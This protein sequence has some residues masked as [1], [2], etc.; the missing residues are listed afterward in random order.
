MLII[1]NLYLKSSLE[2]ILQ[3]PGNSIIPSKHHQIRLI[4]IF[5]D[6]DQK[7]YKLWQ[8]I[9]QPKMGKIMLL[10]FI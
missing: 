6:T 2:L 10:A 5:P 8:A 3:I 7:G 1:L 4:S 9:L